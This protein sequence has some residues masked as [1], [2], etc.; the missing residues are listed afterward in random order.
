M[1]VTNSIASIDEEYEKKKAVLLEKNNNLGDLYIQLEKLKKEKERKYINFQQKKKEKNISDFLDWFHSIAKSM[2]DD[3]K[4]WNDIYLD[5]QKTIANSKRCD[6]YNFSDETMNSLPIQCPNKKINV[7]IL[8]KPII[9]KMK[10][11]NGKFF[12]TCLHIISSNIHPSA[13][14]PSEHTFYLQIKIM[15]PD[16]YSV[17]QPHVTVPQPHVT[18][19]QP[20]VTVPCEKKTK[21]KT[22]TCICKI[23]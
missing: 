12:N 23:L 11:R 22:E 14:Q 15:P 5:I 13:L 4:M 9:Y 6:M 20:H 17:P 19:P 2:D 3:E 10:N 8:P 16:T 18:V 21:H 1:D 7:K